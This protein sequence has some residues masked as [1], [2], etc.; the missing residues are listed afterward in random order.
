M[1]MRPVIKTESMVLWYG[2][3]KEETHQRYQKRLKSGI[4]CG[5]LRG[6]VGSSPTSPLASL[7]CGL[8]HLMKNKFT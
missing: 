7:R 6:S 4:F 3:Q 8:C 5:G 2:G 1:N